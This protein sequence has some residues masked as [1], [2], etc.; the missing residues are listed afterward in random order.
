MN[1]ACYIF[2]SIVSLWS[3]R[4]CAL[5]FVALVYKRAYNQPST[6]GHYEVLWANTVMIF[7]EAHD[8]ENSLL[9]SHKSVAFF[10]MHICKVQISCEIMFTVFIYPTGSL[11]SFGYQ[12]N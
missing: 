6:P 3:L 11:R 9:L 1:V 8:S 4:A 12:N 7:Q 5:F 2:L 10:T